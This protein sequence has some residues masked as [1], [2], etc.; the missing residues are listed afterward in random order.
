MHKR[1][2]SQTK[3]PHKKCDTNDSN[4]NNQGD[5]ERLVNRATAARSFVDARL[6]AT[7]ATYHGIE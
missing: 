2:K 6:Q 3:Q 1:E 7:K 4:N 5:T